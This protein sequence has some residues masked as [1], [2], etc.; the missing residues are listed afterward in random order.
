MPLTDRVV[1]MIHEL[2]DGVRQRTVANVD[3]LELVRRGDAAAG[4]RE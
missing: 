3:E 1:T 2:E 4:V